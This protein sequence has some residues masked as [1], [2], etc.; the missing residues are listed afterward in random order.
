ML[1]SEVE[2]YYRRLLP[3]DRARPSFFCIYVEFDLLIMFCFDLKSH[4][5][6]SVRIE[7]DL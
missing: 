6:E 3:P 4:G 7:V 5:R 2:A 1:I